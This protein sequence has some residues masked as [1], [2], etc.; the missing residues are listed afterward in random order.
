MR[1][2]R[3][4]YAANPPIYDVAE[5]GDRASAGAGD[6]PEFEIGALLRLSRLS[7]GQRAR[8]ERRAENQAAHLRRQ[9][10]RDELARIAREERRK[11]NR[12]AFASRK[13]RA[14]L[15]THSPE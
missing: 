3:L 11:A 2:D 14:I 15:S 12:R 10:E 6:E 13:R 8:L 7:P 1:S 5:Q 4:K 9:E